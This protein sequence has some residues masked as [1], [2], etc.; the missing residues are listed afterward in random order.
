MSLSA[1]KSRIDALDKERASIEKGLEKIVNDY[2]L[3]LQ[4]QATPID[5]LSAS[6]KYLNFFARGGVNVD[7]TG[8]ED[9]V[10]MYLVPPGSQ[11]GLGYDI[12]SSV[13]SDT[14]STFRKVLNS[15]K[16]TLRWD[17]SNDGQLFFILRLKEPHEEEEIQNNIKQ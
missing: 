17:E 15:T 11:E 2:I 5:A 14:L 1:L 9:Q 4:Q 10:N 6:V 12:I 7:E 16:Y 8:K 13:L 3:A